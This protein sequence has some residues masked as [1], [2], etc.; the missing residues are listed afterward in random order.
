MGTLTIYGASDDLI[1]FE[2]DFE[3]EGNHYGDDPAYIHL[4]DGSVIKALYDRDGIWRFDPVKL[5]EGTT[6]K[7]HEK[8]S[9]EE[10][11]PDRL[12]LSRKGGKFRR[13]DVWQSPE[14]PSLSE[15]QDAIERWFDDRGFGGLDKKQA[16]AIYELISSL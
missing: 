8:G 12:T 2:G 16:K 9:V 4:D 10:D 5:A 1:D 7:K 6:V 13:F 14:G 15:L 3:D 11:T